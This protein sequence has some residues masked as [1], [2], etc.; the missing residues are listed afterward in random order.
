MKEDQLNRGIENRLKKLEAE[1]EDRAVHIIWA[2]NQ[3]EADRKL[4]EYKGREKPMLVHWQ[5]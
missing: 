5:W 4:A 2:D 3:A 1:T